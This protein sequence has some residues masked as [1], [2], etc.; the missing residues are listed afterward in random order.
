MDNLIVLDFPFF[1]SLLLLALWVSNL[2]VMGV[3]RGDSQSSATLLF[4]FQFGL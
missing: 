3:G 1:L 4:H 2:R